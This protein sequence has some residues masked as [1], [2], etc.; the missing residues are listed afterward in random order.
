[1][2][3]GGEAAASRWMGWPIFIYTLLIIL[4]SAPPLIYTPDEWGPA[5]WRVMKM[6]CET[7]HAKD[8]SLVTFIEAIPGALPCRSCDGK[9]REVLKKYPPRDFLA[10]GSSLERRRAWYAA[11]RAEVRAHEAPKTLARR[12]RRDKTK[13]FVGIAVVAAIVFA[14]IIAALVCKRICEKRASQ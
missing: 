11:V 7:S 2:G 5:F 12:W 6:A 13:V 14:A 1:M 8:D 10:K 4:M 9:F 3:I